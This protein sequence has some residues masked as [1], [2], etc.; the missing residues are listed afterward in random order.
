MNEPLSEKQKERLRILEPKLKN[1]I[2]EQNFEI[3]KD[4]VLDLQTL[5]RPTNHLVR[6]IQ[7]KNKLY[8]LAIE[9]NKADFAINGLLSNEKVLNENTR[10]YL[11]TISLIAI[12]YL[13]TKNIPSAQEY[14][15][16]VLQNHSVIKTE[17][18]RSIF[19]SEIISRFNEEVA[20]ATLTSNQK[21]HLDED[22][23]ERE[24]IRI[25]QTLTDDEIFSQ[26]GQRSPKATKDLIFQIHDFSTKQLPSAERLALPSPNQMIMDK[27]VGITVFESV[28]RVIYNSLCNPESEIYK[29]WFD[30]GMQMVLSKGY[31][32]S[33]VVSC[34][35]NIGFGI[36]M[37]ASSI[38]ALV[39][40]F[41]IEVYCTKYKPIYISD[42][43][44]IK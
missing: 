23:I 43:R 5:L 38:V 36:S 31:I 28:K 21:V 44:S 37:I 22:E 32:K 15:R 33:A 30:N 40:K 14:I 18:T 29:T 20:M 26:I 41:G 12:C 13:R 39:M 42:I 2:T 1:A 16:K 27:E 24:A 19:H 9:L 7:S 8:E 10:I 11:E 35:V 17:R 6:L 3:A 4:I 25:I 34:L